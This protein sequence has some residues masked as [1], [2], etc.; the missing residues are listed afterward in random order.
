MGASPT[1]PPSRY[2]ALRMGF[3]DLEDAGVVEWV[4]LAD[5]VLSPL[6]SPYPPSPILDASC[7]YEIR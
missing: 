6:A 7:V 3:H 5:L 4:F 2:E 1:V